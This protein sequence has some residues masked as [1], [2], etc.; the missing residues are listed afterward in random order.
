MARTM[1]KTY[2]R[3]TVKKIIKGHSGKNVGRNVDPLVS[4]VCLAAN[5][6]QQLILL[7]Q[8]YLDYVLFI[9]Q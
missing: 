4:A 1:Q 6:Q 8:V 2:P 3:A 9:Q 7:L 5:A